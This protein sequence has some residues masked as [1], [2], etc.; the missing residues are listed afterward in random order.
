V[1]QLSGN[2][3][4]SS[5]LDRFDWLDHGFGA[6]DSESWLDAQPAATLKQIHSAI[7]VEACA[8]GRLGEGDSLITRQPGL[9]IGVRT[10]DCY[11]VV[12]ADPA[13]HAIAVVH[14]GWRGAAAEILARTIEEMT[15]RFSTRPADLNAAIGPGI[16]ACCYEVGAEVASKFTRWIAEFPATPRGFLLDLLSVLRRQLEEMGVREANIDAAALCTCCHPVEFHSFR[17]DSDAAGR[18]VSAARIRPKS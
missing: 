14:A 2:L 9:W 4:R 11:P 15:A 17:R 8:Q 1:F 13:H 7:V 3:L 16:G 18:M 12:L 6:R 10:A 5:A